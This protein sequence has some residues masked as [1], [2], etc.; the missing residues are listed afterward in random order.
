MLVGLVV[1]AALLVLGVIC[2]IL[3][4]HSAARKLD[5]LTREAA[6][7]RGAGAAQSCSSQQARISNL[8]RLAALTTA[9]LS[10]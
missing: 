4:A 8:P 6:T 2:A 3:V 5:A 10:Y 1:A 9:A 7:I